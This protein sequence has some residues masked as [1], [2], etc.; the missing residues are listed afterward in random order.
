MVKSE[1]FGNG[2]LTNE[3]NWS[4]SEKDREEYLNEKILEY[5]HKYLEISNELIPDDFK[6][7][8]ERQTEYVKN[9]HAFTPLKVLVLRD[10]STTLLINFINL[11]F[12]E[13]LSYWDH[14]Q[15]NKE[16]ISWYK[17]DIIIE[18]RTERFLENSIGFLDQTPK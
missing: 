13:L 4:Y 18:I 7:V 11:Y 17:P 1:K 3:E 8:G 16:L 10:S 6:Y 5:N 12:K 15:F 9:E 2:D 14:W